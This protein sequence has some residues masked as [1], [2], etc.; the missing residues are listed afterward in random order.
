M[1]ES[2]KNSRKKKVNRIKGLAKLM[3]GILTLW[4]RKA[5]AGGK[6]RNKVQ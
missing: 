1:A 2:V 4:G 3:S 5:E 6:E